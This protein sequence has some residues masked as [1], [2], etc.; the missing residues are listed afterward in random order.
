[1][2]TWGEL[3]GQTWPARLAQS[4]WS[5]AKLPGDVYAGRVDP[6]SEE[7][8]G[9]AADLAGTV[10]LGPMPFGLVPQGAIGS[11]ASKGIRAYHGSPHDFERFDMSKIG[12]GEGAQAY[13]HGLYFAE[14]PGVAE[15]YKKDLGTV[16]KAFGGV[17][18]KTSAEDM[19]HDILS[20]TSGSSLEKALLTVDDWADAGVFRGPNESRAILDVKR[21]I[22]ENFG[23]KLDSAVQGKTYEVAIHADPEDFLDWDKPLSQQSEKVKAAVKTL[24]YQ[25]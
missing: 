18:T 2:A 16:V 14:N 8:I 12:T 6:L 1:M 20:R 10:T 13:G 15:Q 11:T 5:A 17:P 22:G 9:R 7:G 21:A 3:L 4:V 25:P 19:A 23:K 24:S